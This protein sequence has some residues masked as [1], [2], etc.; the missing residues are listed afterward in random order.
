MLRWGHILPHCCNML[1]TG[2]F[3]LPSG[4]RLLNG[5]PDGIGGTL[6]GLVPADAPGPAGADAQLPRTYTPALLAFMGYT[7]AIISYRLPIGAP[8]IAIALIFAFA[9][10]GR[11]RLAKPFLYL[12]ALS[13]WIIIGSI[14]ADH[15]AVVNQALLG[16]WPKLLVIVFVAFTVLRT[17]AQVRAYLI[18]LLG[19]FLAFP[20][21]GAISNWI[22]GYAPS[23]RAVWNGEFANPNGLGALSILAMSIAAGIVVTERRRSAAWWLGIAGVIVLP[24]LILMTASRGAFLG[25]A[26]FAFAVLI[27][28]RN[29]GRLIAMISVIG[30]LGLM[31]APA[32]AR[33]RLGGIRHLLSREELGAADTEGSATERFTLF[34]V[35]KQIVAD[36][37]VFGVGI[38]AAPWTV[39]D[40]LPSLGYKDL[41]NIY[42][43][44]AA[45]TGI[46]GLGLYLTCLGCVL[47]KSRNVRRRVRRIAQPVS[48]QMLYLEAGLLAFLLT[49]LWGS[50]PF[51]LFFFVQLAVVWALAEANAQAFLAPPARGSAY[52]LGGEQRDK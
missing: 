46:V 50:Q 22:K 45:E 40:Y 25:S 2:G 23:G 42:L 37:P 27:P 13:L 1:C 51:L 39:R 6:V 38:G 41:H 24:G 32:K 35:G 28:A 3:L 21:R 44:V 49:G 9:Q 5:E 30:V 4:G 36:H 31:F 48:Q 7:L 8:A 19:C 18:F 16:S 14:G 34:G 10:K 20:A 12:L 29:K 17:R 52:Q 26:A 33:E 11:V 15:P 47:A 43:T